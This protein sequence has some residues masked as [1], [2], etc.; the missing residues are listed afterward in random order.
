MLANDVSDVRANEWLSKRAVALEIDAISKERIGR[1][2][3]AM[4]RTDLEAVGHKPMAVLDALR[5]RCLDCCAGSASEVR[6]CVAVDCPSWPFRMGWNPWR[7]RR[8]ISE[9]DR[10]A[11]GARLSAA[12]KVRV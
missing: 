7:E 11:L 10:A 8:E 4:S 12:R 1:D 5:A 6:K 2:P 9:Q 3:R